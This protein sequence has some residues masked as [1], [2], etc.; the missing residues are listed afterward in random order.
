[1]GMLRL[2]AALA[3]GT[4]V[5]G[6]FGG[7]GDPC[8][9]ADIIIIY[10]DHS[11]WSPPSWFSGP[12]EYNTLLADAG[13]CQD[14]CDATPGC[15]Y[16][17]YEWENTTGTYYHEC[18]LKQGFTYAECPHP[19]I[20]QYAVWEHDLIESPDWHGV[21]GPAVCTGVLTC[22]WDL[23]DDMCWVYDSFGTIIT[24]ECGLDMCLP[25]S[26]FLAEEIQSA[27]CSGSYTHKV[28][29]VLDG[30]NID[31]GTFNQLAYEGAAAACT[32]AASCCFL[33]ASRDHPLHLWDAYTGALRAH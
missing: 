7:G 8:G 15:D 4:L 14:L 32:E 19:V 24:H 16:F 3:H 10:A 26:D 12:V 31:D 22:E 33:S 2:I 28:T 5:A 9:Y 21:S 23:N 13:A 11:D 25:E 1:M 29:L 18:Y 27:A 17:S 6:Q 20:E 30:G